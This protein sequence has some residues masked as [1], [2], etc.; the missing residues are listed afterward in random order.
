MFH[1]VLSMIRQQLVAKISGDH[2]AGFGMA[3]PDTH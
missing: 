2:L 1:R 3:D